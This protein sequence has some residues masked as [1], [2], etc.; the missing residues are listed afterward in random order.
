MGMAT[1]GHASLHPDWYQIFRI[2]V[3]FHMDLVSFSGTTGSSQ[4]KTM[5][6]INLFKKNWSSEPVPTPGWRGEI[7]S[8]FTMRSEKEATDHRFRDLHC[9]L[10]A[11]NRKLA[12]TNCYSPAVVSCYRAHKIQGLPV[13]LQIK[14]E[15]SLPANSLL[16]LSKELLPPEGFPSTTENA[17][18]VDGGWQSRGSQ[19]SS[20]KILSLA[21]TARQPQTDNSVSATGYKPNPQEQLSFL[22][23]LSAAEGNSLTTHWLHQELQTHFDLEPS[24]NCHILETETRKINSLFFHV[25]D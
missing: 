6:C 5:L 25:S 16:S 3:S 17:L 7:K 22:S 11:Y 21:A 13:L 8:A 1:W 14:C 18:V 24:T 15:E 12:A 10:G 4:T 19:R 20:L 2:N 23:L 9:Y